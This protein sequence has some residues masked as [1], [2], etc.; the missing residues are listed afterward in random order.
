MKARH[1]R[2]GKVVTIVDMNALERPYLADE[3]LPCV[4]YREGPRHYVRTRRE[5]QDA[6][7]VIVPWWRRMFTRGG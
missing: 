7:T 1:N 6:F 5:F 3:W 4:T 2:T